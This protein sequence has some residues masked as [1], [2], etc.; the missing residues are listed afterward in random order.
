M[1]QRVTAGQRL[2][3]HA[4]SSRRATEDLGRYLD[5]L[6]KNELQ[7]LAGDLKIDGH[8]TMTKPDLIRAIGRKRGLD[9]AALTKGEL[10]R[11]G[12]DKGSG[13][14]ASMTKDQLIAVVK[15]SATPDRRT[16]ANANAREDKR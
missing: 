12:R 5:V 7:R 14:R 6:H 9:L 3:A 13:V 16:H 11:I 1:T 8:A 4:A 10:L 15:T 2:P